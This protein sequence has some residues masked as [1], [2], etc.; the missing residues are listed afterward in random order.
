MG[1]AVRKNVKFYLFVLVVALGLSALAYFGGDQSDDFAQKKIEK[2]G[3]AQ[4]LV[5]LLHALGSSAEDMKHVRGVVRDQYPNSDIFAPSYLS[6]IFANTSP[7]QLAA[8]LDR[9][10]Q[11][12]HR[13]AI[14]NGK[15]YH[16]IILVGH[17]IG[18]LVARRAYLYGK[19]Y[20]ADHPYPE[21]QQREPTNLP[22]DQAWTGR[23][24]RIILL[25]G[26]N[27][28]WDFSKIDNRTWFKQIAMQF[29]A[30]L[31]RA[32]GTGK[33][34][35]SVERG[36]PFI[37][38]LRIDWLRM[39]NR[40]AG[41]VSPTIQ[42]LGVRDDLVTPGD[43]LDAVAAPNFVFM[44]VDDTDHSNIRNMARTSPESRARAEVFTQALTRNIDDLKASYPTNDKLISRDPTK[45]HVVFIKHGIRDMA[46]WST[47]LR[48]E[49]EKS[50]KQVEVTIEKFPYFSMLSFLLLWDRQSEV[51]R[52][53]D[54]YATALAKFP[55]A[56]KFS[57]I[58]HSFGTYIVASAMER[59]KSVIFHR[60]YFAGSVVRRDY[61]WTQMKRDQR[62]SAVRNDRAASDWVVAIF[63]RF[64]E[65]V[66]NVTGFENIELLDV[67]S[68]GFNGFIN[69]EASKYDF[70]YLNGGHAAAL[71]FETNKAQA[72]SIARFILLPEL[73]ENVG[74]PRLVD[75]PNKTVRFLGQIAWLIWTV[76]CLTII[77]GAIL[78]GR[79]SAFADHRRIAVLIYLALIGMVLNTF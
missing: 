53:V 68:A 60:L 38:N 51:R 31:A 8:K 6:G 69:D 54:E 35:L 64:F 18:A 7:A 77:A 41:L 15:P 1:A 20:R 76:L 63:P 9:R 67:G 47:P 17:S 58:G 39:V 32:T 25:A 26:M 24:D 5:V 3:S 2:H 42:I 46:D 11:Q 71:A 22:D 37:G 29:G 74:P 73:N 36:A 59:Y 34:P 62:Y 52:F 10:L 23:V 55:N 14:A 12:V 44:R 13:E 16:K 57:F 48:W 28:G 33:L 45:E 70:K 78:V 79:V 30:V 21:L 49:L 4:I 72:S 27:R 66:R 19:G 61:D 40:E 50:S 65:Q 43:D 75:Q 56:Q